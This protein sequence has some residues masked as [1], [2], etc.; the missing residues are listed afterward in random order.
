MVCKE[1]LLVVPRV[2]KYGSL[3]KLKSGIGLLKTGIFA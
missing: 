2:N 1:L 3:T